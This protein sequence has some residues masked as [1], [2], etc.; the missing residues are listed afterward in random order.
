MCIHI[1][2]YIY[3]YIYIHI[4][5]YIYIYTYLLI[6]TY[7]GQFNEWLKNAHIEKEKIHNENDAARMLCLASFGLDLGTNT[8]TTV[9]LYWYVYVHM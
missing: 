5:M 1:Y 8:Y 7:L 3:I 2:I 9:L 6:Y 4:H